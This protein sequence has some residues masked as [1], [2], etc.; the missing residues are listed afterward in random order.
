MIQD[1]PL[2]ALLDEAQ[3]AVSEGANALRD[4]RERYRTAYLE[5]VERWEGLRAR[6]NA[7]NDIVQPGGHRRGDGRSRG[8][9]SSDRC[10]AGSTLPRS[11]SR[12]RGCS[13]PARTPASSTTRAGRRPRPTRRCAS[14][15]PRSRSERGSRA[16]STTDPPRRSPTRSSRSRS[17]SACSTA[18]NSRPATSSSSS[19]RSCPAELRGVRAYLSQLRP[20]LLAEFGLSGAITEAG[21]QIAA[22]LGIPVDRRARGGRRSAARDGRGRRPARGPGSAPERPKARPADVHPSADGARG[23]GVGGRGA[24]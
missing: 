4:V 21:N 16:R 7:S 8:R 14:S 18:T 20:P 11:H 2:S 17:S 10:S 13:S 9:A 5:K 3:A 23:C 12:T 22:A 1:D 24:R 19:A 6:S 15:R